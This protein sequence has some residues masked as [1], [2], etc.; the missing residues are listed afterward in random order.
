MS[1]VFGRLAPYIQDFIYAN[2]WEDLREIQKEACQVVWDTDDNLL[3]SSGTASGKT[4][5][6][7]LPVLTELYHRPSRS[8]GVLYISPL[9]ALINDQFKRLDQL[10]QESGLPVCK[11]HGDA[12]RAE[13]DRLVKHPQGILQ[14]TPES[15]ESLLIRKQGACYS[16]F[17]DLRFVI[18]DEVHYFMRDVRGVQV[19]SL[20]ERMQ[21]LSGNV[22]RRIGLS[23]TLGDIEVA[24]RWLNAGT[25]R[26]CSAPRGETG[27]QKIRLLVE[28]LYI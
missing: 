20:L 6:A 24:K 21:R 4:E 2:H 27:Q 7:F 16:L 23:A 25:P 26:L 8:V 5:A 1:G 22:P 28:R 9:K 13:K 11:W 3:L 15:L 12:S 19:L 18:I 14:I 17:H 10:L